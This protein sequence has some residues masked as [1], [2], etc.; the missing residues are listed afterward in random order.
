M[1]QIKDCLPTLYQEVSDYFQTVPL[2]GEVSNRVDE[3]FN[4]LKDN[5]QVLADI[6]GLQMNPKLLFLAALAR[7]IEIGRRLTEI[8]N[9]EMSVGV[10][11][12]H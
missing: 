6:R 12:K 7:G 3:I 9:L 11:E 4:V 1:A 10:L 8:E 5:P 2:Y